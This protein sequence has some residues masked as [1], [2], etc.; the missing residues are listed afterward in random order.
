MHATDQPPGRAAGIV[1]ATLMILSLAACTVAPPPPPAPPP[2]EPVVFKGPTPEEIEKSRQLACL[3]QAIYFEARGESEIGQQ[4]VGYVVMNRVGNPN[5]AD[6]VCG[7]IRQG[8]PQPPCQFSWYCDGRAD[9]PKEPEAWAEAQRIAALVFAK[10]VPDPTH[11]AHYFHNRNVQP[12]WKQKFK[13]TAE[14]QG[15]I[16]YRSIEEGAPTGAGG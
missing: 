16:Y 4:A 13:S 15:H 6:T 8:G 5:F 3:T 10:S 7:V 2:P 1:G 14:I 9:T 11:G 12:A